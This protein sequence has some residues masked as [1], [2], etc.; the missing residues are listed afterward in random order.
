MKQTPV[1]RFPE[2]RTKA[3]TLS[4]D[5]AV[6]EDVRFIEIMR[7][8]G[9]KG[10][11][12]I[13]TAQYCTEEAYQARSADA[14]AHRMPMDRATVLYG[15]DDTEP[16]LHALT[17]PFLEKLPAPQIAYEIIKDRENLEAQFGRI[18][19]GMAYPFGT[20]NDTVIRVLRDCGI[21]YART[22]KPT[23]G[24]DLPTDFLTWHPTCHHNDARLGELTNRFLTEEP[25]AKKDGFLFY[26]WGHAYEFAMI[27]NWDLIESFAAQVG[28]HEEIWYATNGEIVSYIEAY[29]ALIWSFDRMRVYNPTC[30]PVW[31]RCDDETWR[32]GAGETVCLL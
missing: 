28:G 24:F 20:Y 21:A 4:Y 8:H 16:A 10:T 5:D 11:F 17:H 26:L 12:N 15:Q 27:D 19:R 2:G 3:L 29:R 23:Y 13:N 25:S 30:T 22:T 18:V 1:L 32:I 31:F 9:L 6:C 7:G 14:I